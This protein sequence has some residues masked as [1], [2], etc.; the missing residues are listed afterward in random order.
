MKYR[1]TIIALGFIILVAST[2]LIGVPRSWKDIVVM[3]SALAI[4]VLAYLA[5]KESAGGTDINTQ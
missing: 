3:L 5:K 4:V 1:N 2:S